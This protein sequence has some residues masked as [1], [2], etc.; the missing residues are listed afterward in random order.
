MRRLSKGQ[1][2][3][4]RSR[5]YEYA[6]DL[7]TEMALRWSLKQH[8]H[9]LGQVDPGCRWCAVERRILTPGLRASKRPEAGWWRQ[10]IGEYN[11]A[12]F[13]RRNPKPNPYWWLRGSEKKFI[14]LCRRRTSK[15]ARVAITVRR[16][17]RIVK[18]PNDTVRWNL[19]R[20]GA[21]LARM[22]SPGRELSLEETLA[23]GL[24]F[25]RRH[26]F[27]IGTWSFVFTKNRSRVSLKRLETLARAL[28]QE[29]ALGFY[30]SVIRR[31]SGQRVTDCEKRLHRKRDRTVEPFFL[32]DSG[33]FY[34][35]LVERRT[36][37]FARDW[38]F[39]INTPIEDFR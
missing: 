13:G 1:I 38:D 32:T 27:E 20:Y 26:P 8:G 37:Q 19:G 6:S 35:E 23:C 33:P 36:P 16:K 3:R 14:P 4:A 28:G 11:L 31:L 15:I 9:S 17:I 5:G 7:L 10:F 25:S 18:L 29:K 34:R 2:L 21:R 22:G 12:I 30:L 24:E 39:R